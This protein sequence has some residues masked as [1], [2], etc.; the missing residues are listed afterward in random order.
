[1]TDGGSERSTKTGRNINPRLSK[2]IIGWLADEGIDDEQELIRRSHERATPEEIEAGFLYW[3]RSR[4]TDALSQWRKPTGDSPRAGRN[5]D[6]Q[7]GFGWL[8][9]PAVE[10]MPRM[11][12]YLRRYAKVQEHIDLFERVLSITEPYS[13]ENDVTGLSMEEVCRLAGVTDEDIAALGS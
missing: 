13:A 5:S 6:G 12:R 9:D 11:R 3:L 4:V 10:V 8:P 7:I 1:M 2:L